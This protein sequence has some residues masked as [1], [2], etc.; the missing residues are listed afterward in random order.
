MPFGSPTV[1]LTVSLADLA[2]AQRKSYEQLSVLLTE[3]GIPR[4][5]KTIGSVLRG[6]QRGAPKLIAALAEILTSSEQLRAA[7]VGEPIITDQIA[8]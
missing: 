4:T 2:K 3:R 1:N 5:P 7:G 6:E 8:A